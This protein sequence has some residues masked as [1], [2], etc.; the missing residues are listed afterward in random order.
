MA[1][2]ACSA[3]LFSVVRMSSCLMVY[4]LARYPSQYFV[5]SE[6]PIFSE[7]IARQAIYRA[8]SRV[9]VDPR[10]W[11]FKSL[12]VSCTV[13]SSVWLS[14][15][16]VITVAPFSRTWFDLRIRVVLLS[17]WTRT[18]Y[19]AR[20]SRSWAGATPRITLGTE[21]CTIWGS[22]QPN[23]VFCPRPNSDSAPCVTS[24]LPLTSVH[25][26]GKRNGE[27]GG[28]LCHSRTVHRPCSPQRRESNGF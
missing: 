15:P 10:N 2:P 8:F 22:L 14:S 18:K 12:A 26:P 13:R 6:P 25:H 4:S 23:S 1:R 20:S 11:T 28:D 19:S 5:L 17:I 9:P 16:L 3:S 24:T 7:A 27:R 21:S